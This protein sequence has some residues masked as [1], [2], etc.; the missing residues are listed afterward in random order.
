M[1]RFR[2]S[3]HAATQPIVCDDEIIST[4]CAYVLSLCCARL[5][6]HRRRSLNILTARESM[7]LSSRRR[8]LFLA[9]HRM[10]LTRARK[11]PSWIA[12]EVKISSICAFSVP[13]LVQKHILRIALFRRTICWS[14]WS[15]STYETS[16][17]KK[18]A[19]SLWNVV[20]APWRP[21]SEIGPNSSLRMSL[22][23]IVGFRSPNF[24]QR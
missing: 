2:V 11:N 20:S 14:R 15:I 19:V 5:R 9:L 8:L 1:S 7:G 18:I 12:R 21:C 6:A 4:S 17:R 24:A 16:S 3:H 23:L 13:T 10:V 22:S